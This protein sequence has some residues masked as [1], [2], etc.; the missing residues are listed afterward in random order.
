M[1]EII[2]NTTKPLHGGDVTLAAKEFG[3]PED[4]WIDLSTDIP[5][6]TKNE[7]YG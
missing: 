6:S 2:N 3:L 7:W 5:S 1:S 4:Q